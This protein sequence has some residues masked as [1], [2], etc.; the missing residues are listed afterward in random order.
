MRQVNPDPDLR[1]SENLAVVQEY[2]SQW[3]S[4]ID[5]RG[6]YVIEPS[7][8]TFDCLAFSLLNKAY[9]LSRAS[10][11]LI[12]SGYPDEAFGLA[13]SVIECSLNLRYMTLDPGKVDSRSNDY[14]D[15]VFCE[16]KHFLEQ[17][18]K[19]FRPGR[20]LSDVENRADQEDIEKRWAT[21]VPSRMRDKN[22]PLNDWKLI[23]SND[24]NGWKIAT[25]PHPLDGQI[26]KDDWIRRHYAAD[27]RGGS[28]MVHCSI[29]SLDNIFVEFGAPFK[30]GENLKTTFDHRFEP[31][32]IIVM[33]LYL[34]ARYTFY[35]ANIDG[36]ENFDKLFEDAIAKLVYVRQS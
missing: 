11:A 16:K 17:C 27:H 35:G 23:E 9:R 1:F 14:V 26:N 18:R 31:L 13:R 28:A 7:G 30:V 25:E 4:N 29:R 32:M 8:R 10:I 2:L 5:A 19:Y 36:S 33:N 34:A 12:E 6:I 22:L 20:D 15:F 3:K 21:L 24:W